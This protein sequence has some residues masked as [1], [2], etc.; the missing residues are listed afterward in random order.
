MNNHFFLQNIVHMVQYCLRPTISFSVYFQC[1]PL[2]LQINLCD[3]IKVPVV[4]IHT[5][6]EE[7][8]WIVKSKY[9]K[10]SVHDHNVPKNSEVSVEGFL[11]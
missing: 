8:P 2:Q 5:Q 10:H 11:K 9:I 7:M 3:N 1:H 6:L 4:I